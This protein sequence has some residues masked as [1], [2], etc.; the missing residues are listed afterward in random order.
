VNDVLGL[1]A[2]IAICFAAAGIGGYA[3]SRSLRDWYV[4]LPKPWWNPP[5]RV[6]G[7]VWTVLYAAMAIAA[8][9]VWRVRDDHDVSVALAWFGVQLVLNVLWSVV[10][11]G[12][13]RP[14]GGVVVIALLW[15]AIVATILAFAPLSLPAALLLVPYLAW[16]TFASLLNLAIARLRP[17]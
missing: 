9:L 8:W 13:R 6:F 3:T 16:V 10:F 11:F 1:V 4:A 15:L 7:P 12:A 14:A 5:N 2:S 17:A